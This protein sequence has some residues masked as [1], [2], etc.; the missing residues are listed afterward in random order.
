[1]EDKHPDGFNR[2]RIISEETKE[3]VPPQTISTRPQTS[4]P[5]SGPPRVRQSPSSRPVLLRGFL[6]FCLS[7]SAQTLLLI[8]ILL[9]LLS[10]CR[11]DC[12]ARPRE[13]RPRPQPPHY[14]GGSE[15]QSKPGQHRRTSR[16]P[17]PGSTP[18]STSVWR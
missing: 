1:M 12:R 9:L 2:H 4:R 17:A 7:M 11:S 16:G 14:V 3:P 6:P 8:L 18:I 5:P 15:N 13:L 10:S